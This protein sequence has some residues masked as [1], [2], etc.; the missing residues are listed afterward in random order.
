MTKGLGL[1]RKLKES[2]GGV[3]NCYHI[4]NLSLRPQYQIDLCSIFHPAVHFKG[5][6]AILFA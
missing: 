2:Q 1:G 4:K 6:Q 3:L 5:V